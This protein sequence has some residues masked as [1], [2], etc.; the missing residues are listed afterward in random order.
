V[1][2]FATRYLSAHSKLPDK[3]AV[4]PEM[5]DEFKVFLAQRDIQPNLSEWTRERNWITSR[6]K[7][8]LITQARGVAAGDE[9]EMQRDPQVQAALQAVEKDTLAQLEHGG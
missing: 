7:Q 1:T 8:E 3:F 2:Q 5:L 9:I 4:T 6:L